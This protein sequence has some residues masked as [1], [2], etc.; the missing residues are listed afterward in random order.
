MR[1]LPRWDIRCSAPNRDSRPAKGNR[2]RPTLLKSAKATYGILD[3]GEL[4]YTLRREP[5]CHCASGVGRKTH[6]DSAFRQV[7]WRRRIRPER[8]LRKCIDA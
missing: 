4:R 8:G 7:A 3:S 1:V 6:S 5:R 2:K